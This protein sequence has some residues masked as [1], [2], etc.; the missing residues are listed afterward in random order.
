MSRYGY[1]DVESF[2]R[3]SED[4]RRL[5]HTPR[6]QGPDLDEF[7]PR[8]VPYHELIGKLDDDMTS[9]STGVD[10]SLWGGVPAADL[11]TNVKA[12]PW[13]LRPG[14]T[15]RSGTKVSIGSINGR[16]T[17][18]QPEHAFLRCNASLK[19]TISAGSGT[20]TV[21]NITPMLGS[22]PTTSSTGELT[23]HNHFSWAGDDDAPCKI[24]WN[25]DDQGWDLYQVKCPA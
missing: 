11:G 4:H 20:G 7:A 3:L 18:V 14:E 17:V 16:Y 8:E 1:V 12:R 23:V 24:E 15:L 21:D 19:G 10:V 25:G 9:M 13:F 22:N 2:K 6:T 5:L